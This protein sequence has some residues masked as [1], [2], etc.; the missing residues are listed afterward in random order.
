MIE[1]LKQVQ[2]DVNDNFAMLDKNVTLNL[3]QGDVLNCH[4]Q[5]SQKIYYIE[6]Q[7]F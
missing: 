5:R 4:W 2:H 3:F 6:I 7:M 1:M